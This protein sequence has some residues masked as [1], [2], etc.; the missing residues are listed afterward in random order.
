MT[1]TT[2][3]CPSPHK[4][5]MSFKMIKHGLMGIG[6]SAIVFMAILA[7]SASMR[8]STGQ[9][10][11]Q[12]A[13]IG[14]SESASF[15]AAPFDLESYSEDA[16]IIPVG[17]SKHP[18]QANSHMA[19]LDPQELSVQQLKV[20]NWIAN[21]YRVAPELVARL[22]HESWNIG[23]RTGIDPTLLLA[24]IAIESRFNP[25]A[26]SSVGASGLMQVM[27]SVH[28]EKF[29]RTGGSMMAYD[30]VTNLRVG[31]LV[32]QEHIQRAGSLEGGLKQYVGA[33]G[34]DDY[35]YASKVL[36]ERDRIR[37][38]MFGSTTPDLDRI[39]MAAQNINTAT[40]GIQQASLRQ[41]SAQPSDLSSLR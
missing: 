35:G 39:L 18:V 30:P 7:S 41:V 11:L 27:T 26:Q 31:V 14:S 33:V 23:E 29:E 2:K 40:P 16:N 32:L 22:V 12:W 17:A 25:Y 1:S 37:R 34:P 38:V 10:L 8:N 19:V 28:S 13:G 21:R 24:I 4:S 15:V 6:L 20:A 9:K 3:R 36:A 5:A